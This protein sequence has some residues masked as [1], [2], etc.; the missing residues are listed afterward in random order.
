MG[1]QPD[2]AQEFETLCERLTTERS[3]LA[4]IRDVH[5]GK[6][7]Y[8]ALYPQT[9]QGGAGRAST[10]KP[11]VE[12]YAKHLAAKAGLSR[13]TVEL[14]AA[15][16]QDLVEDAYDRLLGTPLAN[17]PTLLAVLADLAAEQQHEKLALEPAA[18]ESELRDLRAE[19]KATRTAGKAVTQIMALDQSTTMTVA[20][21][22]FDVLVRVV[23]GMA[24]VTI[25]QAAAKEVTAKPHTRNT[26]I[27]K[28][29]STPRVDEIRVR[30]LPV[31]RSPE[32]PPAAPSVPS[33]HCLVD[34]PLAMSDKLAAII[35]RLKG[36]SWSS[37][38]LECHTKP[39]S[40][41]RRCGE[42]VLVS[43]EDL[44]AWW[45]VTYDTEGDLSLALMVER[46]GTRTTGSLPDATPD[47]RWT[48]TSPA[49]H[50][51]GQQQ[52]AE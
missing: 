18:L 22:A 25:G 17:Q 26:A 12:P 51:P 4:A 15:I 50:A 20:G 47:V 5:A 9:R 52:A 31:T 14:Y 44:D 29:A 40:K 48:H 8:E 3:V 33:L 41:Q 45:L 28:V 6:T 19:G 21:R 11:K 46:D 35:S 24:E 23:N 2:V 49:R 36:D 38:S 34:D 13:R 1:T 37:T 43:Y 32:S 30:P 7:L 10:R 39:L 42:T 16:G 27:T